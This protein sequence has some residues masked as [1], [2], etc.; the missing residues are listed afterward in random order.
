M[1]FLEALVASNRQN[2][3]W[4]DIDND[5]LPQFQKLASEL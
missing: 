1:A 3:I 4:V 2:N 5:P